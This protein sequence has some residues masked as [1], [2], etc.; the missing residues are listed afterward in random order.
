MLRTLRPIRGKQVLEQTVRGRYAAGT[1]RGDKV[2]GYLEEIE[3]ARAEKPQLSKDSK[4]ETYVA[5]RIEL[6]SWRWGGVP[7]YLRAGK[8]LAKRVAEVAIHFSPCRTASS[9]RPAAP[10][11]SPT[12]W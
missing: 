10:P 11:T 1:V 12:R 9:R 2:P 8:R 3:A 6:E 5:M 4:T 7:F